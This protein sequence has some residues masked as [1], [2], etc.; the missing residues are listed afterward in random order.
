MSTIEMLDL[1]DADD[2]LIKAV[3]RDEVY[4]ENLEFVRVIDAFIINREGK[5]WI[6][7]RHMQKRI[8]PGGFDMGVG[9]HVEHGETYLEAF[10]K[11]AGEELGW[12]IGSLEYRETGKY[13]PKDGL[14]QVVS[15]VYEIKSDTAPE[16]NPDDFTSAEW[17]TPQEVAGKIAAGHPA[18]MNLLP[19]LKLVYGVKEKAL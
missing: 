6:P 4:E 1:V 10:R 9:G 12:D 17:L 11:E 16:L 18:K 7:T 5:I 15:T 8:M 3:S 14:H 13:G 2:N 19:L